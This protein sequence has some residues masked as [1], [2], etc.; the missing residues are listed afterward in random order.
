MPGCIVSA[1]T[2]SFRSVEK[3]RR[4]AMPVIT[5]TFENV[6][7]IG[8]CLG[9][10]LGPPANAGVRSKRGAVHPIAKVGNY[11]VLNIGLPSY[12]SVCIHHWRSKEAEAPCGIL[13]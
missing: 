2:A 12:L 7:D 6:S 13:A 11:I 8:V 10:C 1:T 4:R 9:L 3:R 5:S